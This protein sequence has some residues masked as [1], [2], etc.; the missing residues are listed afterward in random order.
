MSHSGS[1]EFVDILSIYKRGFMDGRDFE[2]DAIISAYE[3][4]VDR[5]RAENDRSIEEAYR[6]GLEE[7]YE[8]LKRLVLPWSTVSPYDKHMA[9][10]SSN[11][12][13]ILSRYDIDEIIRAIRLVDAQKRSSS[14]QE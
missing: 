6:R 1:E 2:C 4:G 10:G 11:L 8:Y 13:E 9:F 7:A 3:R 5:E 12:S 14:R